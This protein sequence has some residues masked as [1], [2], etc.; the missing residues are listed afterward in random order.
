MR[1]VFVIIAVVAVFA[2]ACGDSATTTT[3]D[4]AATT[5]TAAAATTTTAAA[6]TTAAPTTTAPA[7]TTTAAAPVAVPATP[8]IGFLE[9]YSPGGADLFPPGSV[10]AHWYQWDG[11]YVVL[12]R[13]FDAS[14]GTQICAGN[15]SRS[16]ASGL[17]V[18]RT[19][20]T[21][22]RSMRSASMP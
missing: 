10:E 8:I 14:D 20:H 3:A 16:R 2:T 17:A 5:T 7:T 1:R 12:Y 19:P 13:G 6:T 22:E 4:T 21:M 18:S 15:S 9:P 11:L